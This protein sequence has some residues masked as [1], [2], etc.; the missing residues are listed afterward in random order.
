M[1]TATIKPAEK[2]K[3]ANR[4]A[5]YSEIGECYTVSFRTKSGV[6]NFYKKVSKICLTK[7]FSNNPFNNNSYGIFEIDGVEYVISPPIHSTN[8]DTNWYSY[9]KTKCYARINMKNNVIFFED[10]I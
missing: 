5:N 7:N 3:I 8:G 1:K 6:D 2:I 9:P 10:L 4:T